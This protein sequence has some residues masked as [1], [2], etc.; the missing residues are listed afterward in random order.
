MPN[1]WLAYSNLTEEELLDEPW[2]NQTLICPECGNGPFFTLRQHNDHVCACRPDPGI[3]DRTCYQCGPLVLESP[4]LLTIHNNI[5]H[6]EVQGITVST[7][8][9]IF[10]RTCLLCNEK[11]FPSAQALDQHRQTEHPVVLYD[12]ASG[13][14][15]TEDNDDSKICGIC[16]KQG[17]LLLHTHNCVSC[18]MVTD[19]LPLCKFCDELASSP[20]AKPHQEKQSRDAPS[21]SDEEKS[22]ILCDVCGELGNPETHDTCSH[23]DETTML[24]HVCGEL[25]NPKT[26]SHDGRGFCDICEQPSDDLASHMLM[27]TSKPGPSRQS[28]EPE[29]RREH[30]EF[31]QCEI[32]PTSLKRHD[33]FVAH[34]K[35]HDSKL[36]TECIYCCKPFPSKNDCQRHVILKHRKMIQS[37]DEQKTQAAKDEYFDRKIRTYHNQ[38]GAGTKRKQKNV[39]PSC[40][41]D[42]IGPMHLCERPWYVVKRHH[43]E[44]HQKFLAV[45]SRWRVLVRDKYQEVQGFAAVMDHLEQLFADILQRVLPPPQEN[46]KVQII[47]V[48][49]LLDYPI[50]IGPR[51]RSDNAEKILDEIERVLQ[52]HEEFVLDARLEIFVTTLKLPE[53]GAYLKHGDNG[54]DFGQYLKAKQSL[55][56][57]RN[58][59]ELCCARALYIGVE[60]ARGRKKCTNLARASCKET[61]KAAE[62]LMKDADIQEG[63]C[64]IPELKKL[65][66]VLDSYQ[67]VVYL[68][69]GNIMF[70]GEQER[71]KKICLL[72]S[73]GHYNV[74][75]HAPAFFAKRNVCPACKKLY[76]HYHTCEGL[77]KYCKEPT[78]GC[79]GLWRKCSECNMSLKGDTCFGKHISNGT[80][81]KYW[82]CKKCSKV[83]YTKKRKAEKHVCDERKC[84]FCKEW[85]MR[86]HRCHIQ[87]E[88]EKKDQPWRYIFYDFETASDSPDCK[89]IPV[90]CAVMIKCCRC[91]ESGFCKKCGTKW[92]YGEDTVDKFCRWLFSEV[93]KNSVA[94]AHNNRAFDAMFILKWLENE[95]FCPEFIFN[96]QKC[97]FMCVPKMNLRIL[98]SLNYLCSPLRKLPAMFNFENIAEKGYF[99]HLFT[100]LD[101]LDYKGG[102]PGKHHFGYDYMTEKEKKEFDGWYAQETKKGC[103]DFKTEIRK[104]CTNDVEVLAEAVL[105][106]KKMFQRVTGCDPYQCITIASAC[107]KVYRTNFLQPNTIGIIPAEGYLPQDLQS[108]LAM[109]WITWTCYAK[110]KK[111]EHARSLERERKINGVKTDAY[112]PEAKTA[113]FFQGCL[114]HG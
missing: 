100:S 2:P 55:I 34:M 114:W 65:Q 68:P 1:L 70:C 35:R 25:C 5:V 72:Y 61:T 19:G 87:V 56:C 94:F 109:E 85:V 92:F 75:T 82:R 69:D 16:G 107:H 96:G 47:L 76:R 33:N 84:S 93:N 63:K 89:H 37:L 15:P 91:P 23:G 108:G 54:I 4:E 98:D 90:A 44:Q 97:L 28:Q 102:W 64:G 103:F 32:C 48:H 50:V 59:D 38:T 45:Q 12:A 110:G 106:F 27:H 26:H 8:E 67:I 39:C 6:P 57:I 13:V 46:Q 10:E 3:V 14:R 11:V 83:L 58:N 66:K 104:Y 9:N 86:D 80:C 53:G 22:N 51:K 105:R 99:P 111:L 77:C 29:L 21:C 71:A 7:R 73:K 20:H 52:S 42:D 31:Y 81:K 30:C 18:D 17:S 41:E 112:D 24:C 79:T 101:T 113:Y 88:K 36:Y 74:I 40:E 60:H 95:E 43:I 78:G 62:K 49:P